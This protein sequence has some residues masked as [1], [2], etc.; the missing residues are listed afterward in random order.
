MCFF[1]VQS[2]MFQGDIFPACPSEEPALTAEE[3]IS[4]TDKD[5]ILMEF[6]SEGAGSGP[7]KVRTMSLLD[8]CVKETPIG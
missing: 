2:E 1:C 4:G 8:L 5:P 3:W 7:V 6:S